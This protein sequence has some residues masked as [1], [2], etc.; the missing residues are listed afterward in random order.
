MNEYELNPHRFRELKHFCL[1]Y[2]FMKDELKRLRATDGYS[3]KRFDPT[4]SLAIREQELEHALKL[5]ETTAHDTED[6]LA[7][8]ILK[9][10]T[11][12]VNVKGLTMPCSRDCMEQLR[13]RYF[14]LLHKKKGV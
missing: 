7:D 8:K 12:D 5:I 9:V 4:S 3:E 2:G 1:Q 10:V 11:E 6:F 14:W 13:R